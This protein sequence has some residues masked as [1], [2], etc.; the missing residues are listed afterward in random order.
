MK[1]LWGV[2]I[3]LTAVFAIAQ[4]RVEAPKIT[5][6]PLPPEALKASP[7]MTGSNLS[8]N[9]I[10]D[11]SG[12][13][14]GLLGNSTKME[15]V[16]DILSDL[17]S[18]WGQVKDP[19]ISLGVRT[20]GS[21][22]PAEAK[23]CDDSKQLHPVAPV[24]TFN[25]ADLLKTVN[26]QGI[27]PI[28]TALKGGAEDLKTAS[29]DKMMVLLTD[30]KDRCGEDP[31][32]VAKTLYE[33]QQIVTHV[34]AFDIPSTEESSVKCIADN[35]GGRYFLART[36]EELITALD[37]SVRSTLP[38]NLRFKI[39]VGAMPVPSQVT[40]Y[41]AGTQQVV[42]ERKSFG[43]ELLS[44]N[45]GSYDILVEYSD[46]VFQSKPSKILKGLSVT[47]SGKLEEE[48]RF[49]LTPLT[50][51]ASDPQGNPTET[52]FT[53]I[54]SGTETKVAQFTTD[55]KRK[56][57]FIKPGKYD[58]TAKRLTAGSEITLTAA[59]M[60]ILPEQSVEKSF[61]FQMGRLHLIGTTPQG[62]KVPFAYRV[63]STVNKEL[64]I[65]EGRFSK[66]GGDIELPPGNVTV[67]I[68]GINEKVQINPMGQKENI[69][70]AGGTTIEET[71]LLESGQLNLKAVK[72]GK[73]EALSE[74][75]IHNAETNVLVTQL[76]ASEGKSS[77]A[78]PPGK[79]NVTAKLLSTRYENPPTVEQK[80][81]EIKSG[82]TKD[83]LL[84]FTLGVIKVLGRNTKEKR[85]MSTFTVYESGEDDVIAQVKESKDWV[86]FDLS[87]GV[88][89]IRAENMEAKEES[90]PTLWQREIEVKPNTLTVREMIFTNA[91]LRLIGRGTNN[92]II[93][94]QF[95]I[96]KYG[97]DRPI[98]SGLTGQDWETYDINPDS[99]YI[100]ASYHDFVTSQ[101]LKKWVSLKVI[102]NQ[103]VEKEL[104][105]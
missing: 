44:L 24:E 62:E 25:A 59:G 67:K 65:A 5:L 95:K 78:L 27:G 38:Y 89:D 105:F 68:E 22:K 77:L 42:L 86:Q 99:Y 98:L 26:A 81:I 32:I 104:R 85:L 72:A 3:L 100:E 23:A 57:Y 4:N 53:L 70:V 101:T 28:A 48:V 2:L 33:T 40:V 29:G 52:E 76:T 1:R 83:L 56:T 84:R 41:K 8:I 16:Q 45:P 71:I 96:Y 36:R 35:S 10:L 73:E 66:E 30:G 49:E 93:P 91:K 21:E 75:F 18:H 61:L 37:E 6:T 88:Y 12:S 94:V 11:A 39:S 51:E 90:R 20:F 9:L 31:C 43:V 63:F 80:N 47:L 13:M 15:L 79:Y 7:I 34:V 92:E 19:I 58:L 55:G 103:L 82:K 74:I 46:S 69:E 60:D 14:K 50:L 54:P 64:P 87:P 102:E 17:S 97:Q